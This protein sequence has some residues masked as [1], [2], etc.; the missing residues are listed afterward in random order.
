MLS[1]I[2]AVTATTLGIWAAI[3]TAVSPNTWVNVLRALLEVAPVSGSNTPT[4][5]NVPASVS[6]GAY[7]LPLRVMT[8][9][10]VGPSKRLR[11]LSVS[12]STSRSWPSMGPKYLKPIS[13]NSKPGTTRLWRPSL[14]RWASV[15]ALAPLGSLP[16]SSHTSF[17]NARYSRLVVSLV[18]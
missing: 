1:V 12:S 15:W 4:P 9:S 11:S 13:S 18:R 2:A 14:M 8:C 7:P 3:S 5:W 16:S 17:S 6:A 10:R